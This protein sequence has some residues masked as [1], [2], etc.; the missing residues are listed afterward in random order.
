MIDPKYVPSLVKFFVAAVAVAVIAVF[1]PVETT[2]IAFI[3]L[4][5]IACF[6]S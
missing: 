5:I 6:A 3:T 4:A 2:L 1:A